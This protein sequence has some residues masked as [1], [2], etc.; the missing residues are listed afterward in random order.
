MDGRRFGACETRG[1][2]LPVHHADAAT[3]LAALLTET[4][5]V[6]V[7]HLGLAAGRARV[8]LERVA[9]NGLDYDQPDRTGFQASGE[10]IAPGGPAPDFPTLPL[11]ALPQALTPA[12]IPAY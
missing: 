1:A 12:G 3:R 6:A 9:V 5:P 4:D 10:P 7:V 8:A 11:L 2:V